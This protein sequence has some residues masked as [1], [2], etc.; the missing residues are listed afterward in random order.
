MHDGR[1]NFRDDHAAETHKEEPF[2]KL[3]YAYLV[4]WIGWSHVLRP[5]L[6]GKKL[7][8]MALEMKA[9]VPQT[10]ANARTV[11]GAMPKDL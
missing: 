9:Q 6:S 8:A 7:M 3:A 10:A 2:A 11:V 4:K 5:N 1:V